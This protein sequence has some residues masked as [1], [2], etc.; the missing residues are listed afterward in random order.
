LSDIPLLLFTAFTNFAIPLY[1]AVAA[2]LNDFDEFGF[3]SENGPIEDDIEV[4]FENFSITELSIFSNIAF[5]RCT[6]KSFWII[7]F[8]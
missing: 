1:R 5:G 2:C 8:L 6:R 4:D 7:S 3:T